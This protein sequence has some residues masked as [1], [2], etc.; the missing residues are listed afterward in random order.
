MFQQAHL[1]A[2]ILPF[3]TIFCRFFLCPVPSQPILIMADLTHAPRKR[4][5]LH[6]MLL[7]VIYVFAS[8]RNHNGTSY[9]L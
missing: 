1:R 2:L 4:A 8:G 3:V 5:M 7:F 9:S 6:G